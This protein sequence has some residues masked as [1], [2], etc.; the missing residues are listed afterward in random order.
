MDIRELHDALKNAIDAIDGAAFAREQMQN[1]QRR[2]DRICADTQTIQDNADKE[3][4][5]AAAQVQALTKE[6]DDL[7]HQLEEE[8][9][10]HVAMIEYEDRRSR[11]QIHKASETLE[12]LNAEIRLTRQHHDDLNAAIAR[13]KAMAQDAARL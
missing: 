3:K 4:A 9:E 2:F 10:K 6:L 5:L 13:L 11:E 1:A 7:R 8:R 12:A